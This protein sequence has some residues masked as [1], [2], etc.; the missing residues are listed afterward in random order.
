MI[1]KKLNVPIRRTAMIL[2]ILL[3]L[4]HNAFSQMDSSFFYRVL[5][6][7][8]YLNKVLSNNLEYASEKFKISIA[9]ARIEAA[10]IFEN[11]SIE[12]DYAQNREEN[13]YKSNSL[14]AEISKTF[15]LGRK[16]TARIIAAKSES[17]LVRNLLDDY[18]RNLRA[19]A[20]LDYLTAL[21][22]KFLYDVMLNSYQ[23]M[24]ELSEADSI[25][26]S[27]GSI[28]AIDAAQSKIE[29]G[30]LLNN[31]LQIDADRKNAFLNLST[32]A[33]LS[34]SDT[35]ILPTGKFEKTERPFV[36]NE[37]LTVALSKR[38]DLLAA[39]NNI[40][41][42]QN[43][44]TLTKSERKADIDLKAGTSHT[45]LNHGLSTPSE[46]QIYAGAT[47]PLKF[48]NLN[49]GDIKVARFQVDQVELMYKQSE[50]RIQNEVVKAYFQYKSLCKQVENY[51]HGL[52]E[53]A[54]GVLDGKVYSYSR[55]ETSLLEV[56]NA[57]RTYNDLQTSY[58]E[59]LY[60]CNEALIELER[61][62]GFCDIDL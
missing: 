51:N 47:I 53:K 10:S 13:N 8:E 32:R 15:E 31:L 2:T 26:F 62:V 27:L 3:S 50:I 37:L 19:D 30:I 61:S 18:L 58:Y 55:G 5:S 22:Q 20:T 54:K 36:L 39:K 1:N 33:S 34:H 38:A 17:T 16:R 44:L 42:Q 9:D 6:Y 49:K 23:M 59:T 41:I 45:Y 7:R 46:T 24:K 14:T 48:S 21:K 56:L 40:T 52:L 29:A 35:I 57:Q 12:I 11:P 43:L 28:K 60:N 25:R 4:H